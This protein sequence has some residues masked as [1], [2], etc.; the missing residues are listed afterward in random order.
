MNPQ[1]VSVA[2]NNK[3]VSFQEYFYDNREVLE[4]RSDALI[5]PYVLFFCLLPFVTLTI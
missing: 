1:R 3:N 5:N 4:I 2:D